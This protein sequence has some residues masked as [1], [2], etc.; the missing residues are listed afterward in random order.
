MHYKIN[1]S[2]NGRHFFATADH[3]ITD[4]TRLKEVLPAIARAFPEGEGFE[5]SVTR[6]ECIG[7]NRDVQ[8]ILEEVEMDAQRNVRHAAKSGPLENW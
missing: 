8:N 7:Y 6:W 1:V 2:Q 3:S 5:V 4:Y